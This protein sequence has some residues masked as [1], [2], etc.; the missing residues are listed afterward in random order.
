MV[1]SEHRALQA[2]LALH[3]RAGDGCASRCLDEGG[4]TY[5]PCDTHRA[6]ETEMGDDALRTLE[7]MEA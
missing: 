3:R 7:T 2:V 1:T 4:D 6:V 5:W